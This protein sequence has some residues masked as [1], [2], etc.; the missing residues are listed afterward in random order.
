MPVERALEILE[1]EANDGML[2]KDVVELFTSS[3]VYQ[4]VLEKDWREF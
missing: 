3:G 1:W 2:D 4:K